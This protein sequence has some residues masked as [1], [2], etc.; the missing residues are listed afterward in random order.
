MMRLLVLLVLVTS[1]VALA[2]CS[3][4]AGTAANKSSAGPTAQGIWS[5]PAAAGQTGVVYLKLTNPG[6]ADN[7]LSASSPVAEAVEI[8][9]TM[10]SQG[11]TMMKPVG[12]VS[13]PAGGSVELKPGGIHIMLINV[14]QELKP[15]MTIPV[16][17]N[18]EKAGAM[19]V[20]SEVRQP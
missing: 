14:K 3:T 6:Q 10:E 12:K 20:T 19:T 7:L 13:L 8:H 1:I 4:P 5:R 17:L 16:T 11:M 2:G 15:G 18:F 9:E